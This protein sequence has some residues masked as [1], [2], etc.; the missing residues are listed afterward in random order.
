MGTG[1]Y[2]QTTKFINGKTQHVRVELSSREVKAYIMKINRLSSTQYKKQYD[3]FKNK[4]RAFEAFEK[5]SGKKVDKQSPVQILYKQAKAKETA[6]RTGQRYKPSIALKRIQKFQSV[7]SGKAGQKLLQRQSYITKQNEVYLK[8]TEKA[9][10]NFIF[11]N[12]EKGTTGNKQA[13][14]I[15]EKLKD[16]P[17]KLEQALSDY[18][19]ALNAKIKES[20]ERV[21][22]EAIPFGETLG[23]NDE[24]DFDINKYL[25]YI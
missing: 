25:W 9:F 10:N 14:E 7:S 13:Q 19:D 24:I 11:G 8:A 16:D 18:A 1:L 2:K 4:L 20:G 23:S 12:E 5:A 15:Y 6:R 3:I 22:N 17:V 21:E